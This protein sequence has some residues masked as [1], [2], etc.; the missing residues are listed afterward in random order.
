M[1]TVSK[2]TIPSLRCPECESPVLFADGELKEGTVIECS[3]C[4]TQSEIIQVNPVR[5]APLEEEK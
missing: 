2:S 1:A 4:G 5:L 3:A